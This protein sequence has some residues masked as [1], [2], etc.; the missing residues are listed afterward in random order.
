MSST[1]ITYCHTFR[2]NISHLCRRADRPKEARPI[3]VASFAPANGDEVDVP[4]DCVSF[5]EMT[6]SDDISQCRKEVKKLTIS[7]KE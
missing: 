2:C 6:G 3:S 4:S 7:K 1:D 5:M